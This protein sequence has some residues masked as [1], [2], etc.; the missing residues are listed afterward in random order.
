M[1]EKKIVIKVNENG[2]IDAETFNMEGIDCVQ[3][4]DRLMKNLAIVTE[5]KKKPEY[6]KNKTKSV[7]KIVNKKG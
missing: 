3:E 5:E 2:E 6:Y 4:L 1:N 7:T